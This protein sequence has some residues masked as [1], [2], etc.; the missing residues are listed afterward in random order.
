MIAG[1]Y[2]CRSGLVHAK[3]GEVLYEVQEAIPLEHPNEES[4]IVDE[5]LGFLHAVLRL[6][7]HEAVFLAG[8]GACLGE[9]HI[10]HY[11]EDVVNEQGR[12]FLNVVPNL[13]VCSRSVS[14]F[15]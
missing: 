5:V 6:P 4:V 9:C 8:N 2:L 15:P 1:K 11:A 14:F 3:A 12:D 7:L 10:T 13:T